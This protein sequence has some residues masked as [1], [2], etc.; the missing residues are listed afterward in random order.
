MS[1]MLIFGSNGLLGQSLIRRFA[2]EFDIIGASIESENYNKNIEMVYQPIDMAVRSDMHEFLSDIQPDIIINAAAYTDVDK[3]EIEREQCWN[4]NVRAVENIVESNL[5]PKTTIIHLSTDYV[6][7]GDNPPYREKDKPNPR[8]N[9][10]RSKMASENVISAKHFEYLI[11]RTQVLYGIGNRLRP[12]FVTW[13]INQLKNNKKIFVVTD[14]IGNPTYNHDVSESIYRLL[15]TKN[16]GIFHVSGSESIS[17]YDFAL[18]IAEV[19][20]LNNK[21]IESTI[22]NRLEQKAPRPANS[23]FV[24]DKLYNNIGWLPNNAESGLKLLKKELG[25]VHE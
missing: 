1:K 10:A 19:F 25:S 4:A 17:R 2:P 20:N 9:Y 18:K 14:Q 15:K 12:N 22:T 6:F 8:G 23:T 13:V 24:L 11:I 16:F 5:N 21:L 3:C 7:D